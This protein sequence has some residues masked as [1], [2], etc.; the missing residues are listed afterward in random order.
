MEIFYAQDLNS[1][2]DDDD[3]EEEPH[4]IEQPMLAD[5][6]D[7]RGGPRVNQEA[8]TDD[9]AIDMEVFTDATSLSE[10]I[11]VDFDDNFY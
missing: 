6:I 3:Q 8:L 1:L 11:T 2:N 7:Y 9:W 4:N 5:S 10:Q